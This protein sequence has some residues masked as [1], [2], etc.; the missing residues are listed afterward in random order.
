[1]RLAELAAINPA[2]PVH[3]DS[4]EL[5]S[6]LPMNAVSEDDAAITTYMTR[7][8]REVS[9][10]YVAF[11]ERDVLLAKITPCMENGNGFHGGHEHGEFRHGFGGYGYSPYGCSYPYRSYYGCY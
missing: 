3:A 4:D 9:K 8:Y 6:F 10:G 11:A 1:M 2:T 5:C 7:P